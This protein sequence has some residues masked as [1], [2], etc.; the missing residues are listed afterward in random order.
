MKKFITATLIGATALSPIINSAVSAAVILTDPIPSADP[1]GLTSAN[2]TTA[3]AQCDALAV[4]MDLDG[5]GARSDIY[6][7]EVVEIGATLF[8]GPTEIGTHSNADALGPLVPADDATAQALAPY[9]DGNPY[10]NGGSVNMFGVQKTDGVRYSASQ[11]DFYG[12]FRTTYRHE[13]QCEVFKETFVPGYTTR[14]VGYYITYDD[15]NGADEQ[16]VRANCAQF[17]DNGQP[18]WGQLYRPSDAQRHCEFVGTQGE[19][20]PDDWEAPVSQGLFAGGFFNQSQDDELLAHETHGESYIDPA[21]ATIGQVV[22]C[23][24]PSSTGKK[25]PGEWLQKNGYT[26]DKCNTVWYNG[27]A[28]IDVPNL[29]DGS[30]NFVTVPLV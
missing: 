21:T 24:S 22:V 4:T 10:R 17:S 8:A 30:H 5:P 11:Y 19:T 26:G 12:D 1:A 2:L 27:G 25:L 29:N 20:V 9:I 3:Q 13:Y 23:I 15:G 7:A 6:T 16:A 28:T 14:P 18:W